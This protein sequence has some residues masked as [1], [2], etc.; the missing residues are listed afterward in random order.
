LEEVHKSRSCSGV[1]AKTPLTAS[2]QL[3]SEIRHF[4]GLEA[5]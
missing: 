3:I 5:R 2:P 4:A 1:S